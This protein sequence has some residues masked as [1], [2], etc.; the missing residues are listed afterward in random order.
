[1]IARYSDGTYASVDARERPGMTYV[2]KARKKEGLSPRAARPQ[3]RDTWRP[4]L[5]ESRNPR[6]RGR[7]LNSGNRQGSRTDQESP[8][9]LPSLCHPCREGRKTLLKSALAATG[10]SVSMPADSEGYLR[11]PELITK[12]RH[13]IN[14]F[15]LF[16]AGFSGRPRRA[17]P[18]PLFPCNFSGDQRGREA[19]MCRCR[20][21]AC[22]RPCSVASRSP[23]RLMRPVS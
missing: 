21:A 6:L 9:N 12:I 8:L 2:M 1:M 7:S 11:F 13:E 5:Y 15:L 4:G 14:S 18:Y 20:F 19:G 22:G 10:L 17:P 23:L 16:F 3:V